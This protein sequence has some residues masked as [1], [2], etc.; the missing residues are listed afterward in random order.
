MV[1]VSLSALAASSSSATPRTGGALEGPHRLLTEYIRGHKQTSKLAANG[2]GSTGSADSDGS[3]FFQLLHTSSR[4]GIKFRS[5]EYHSKR[6]QAFKVRHFSFATAHPIA[7]G[8]PIAFYIVLSLGTPAVEYPLLFET[9]SDLLWVQCQCLNSSDYSCIQDYN[10]TGSTG[11]PLEVYDPSSSK[12]SQLVCVDPG[13][14]RSCTVVPHTQKECT[15]SQCGFTL[16]YGN[17]YIDG[18]YLADVV[19][20]PMKGTRKLKSTVTFGCAQQIDYYLTDTFGFAGGVGMQF[21]PGSP[22]LFYQ[23]YEAGLV[24][25]VMAF[26]LDGFNEVGSK[27]RIGAGR[28]PANM[29]TTP[30]L[31]YRDYNPFVNV[32]SIS[33]KGVTVSGTNKVGEFCTDS[34]CGN[35]TLGGVLVDSAKSF[36]AMSSTSYDHLKKL[37]GGSKVFNYHTDG[38]ECTTGNVSSLPKISINFPTSTWKI[39]PSTYMFLYDTFFGESVYCLG[40]QPVPNMLDSTGL[41]LLIGTSW[42]EN[43]FIQLDFVNNVFGFAP[44]N[45]TAS[46]LF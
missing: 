34:S 38:L 32:T 29:Q 25:G 22:S 40:V 19:R 3:L 2:Q 23:L 39:P 37:I 8:V 43:N 45:C 46:T 9:A 15:N 4:L 44:R 1:A 30:L 42:L 33:V 41:N 16:Q 20:L 10:L 24:K 17:S 36:T 14:S 31:T 13:D 28:T 11:T 21:Y 7:S 35:E 12:T 27:V 6:L 5:K 18:P 26:C